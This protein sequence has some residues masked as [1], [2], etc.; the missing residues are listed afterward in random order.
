MFYYRPDQPQVKQNVIS[1][2]ANL[3]YELLHKLP[4]NLR[5]RHFHRWR[6][7]AKC[8]HKKKKDLGSQEIRKYLKNLNLGGDIAQRP[9]CPPKIKPWLQQSKNVLKQMSNLPCPVQFPKISLSCSKYLARDCRSTTPWPPRSAIEANISQNK[10]LNNFSPLPF[11]VSDDK[12]QLY[13]CF[14][15]PFHKSFIAI[16]PSSCA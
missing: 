10:L 5:L 8:P 7:G 9:V 4:N 14:V 12:V 6:E 11:Y 16:P 13:T 15:C 1:N 3:V 2:I